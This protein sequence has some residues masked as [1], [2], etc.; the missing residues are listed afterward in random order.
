[1]HAATSKE[2]ASTGRPPFCRKKHVQAHESPYKVFDTESLELD[3]GGPPTFSSPSACQDLEHSS[4]LP[5][6]LQHVLRR[7]HAVQARLHC[8]IDCVHPREPRLLMC[9]GKEGRQA[10]K[11]QANPP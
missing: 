9:K 1:M 10:C 5:L 6:R 2:R 8:F 11:A 7:V 3:G 4:I